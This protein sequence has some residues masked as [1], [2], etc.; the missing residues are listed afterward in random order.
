MLV[1]DGQIEIN[2]GDLLIG[3]LFYYPPRQPRR[4]ALRDHS[5]AAAERERAAR[6]VGETLAALARLARERSKNGH[7]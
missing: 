3:V 7:L 2:L 1:E 4:K 5:R 6:T